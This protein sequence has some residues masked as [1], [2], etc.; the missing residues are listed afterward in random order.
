MRKGLRY[1][2]LSALL[3]AVF[4]NVLAWNSSTFC[5]FYVSNIF[6]V[7]LNTYGKWTSRFP[8]SVG[9]I[10]IVLAVALLIVFVVFT[11]IA[12]IFLMSKK[13]KQKQEKWT[14]KA[15]YK[16]LRFR[17]NYGR[18]NAFF[19]SLLVAITWI[20]TLNCYILYHCTTFEEKYWEDIVTKDEY[21]IEELGMLRDFVVTRANQYAKMM[22]RDENGLILYDGNMEEEA[23]RAMQNLGEVYP[24]LAGFYTTPKKIAA[25]EFLSQQYMKGYY[26][27]F[28]LEANYNDVMYIMSKPATMCHELAHTKGFI[29]EDEANL[30]GFLACLHSDDILFQYSGY[31]SVL[32][33]ID[34]D[35]YKSVDENKQIYN[36][37]VKISSQV[38]KDRVFLTEDAWTKVEKKAVISTKTLK[39][40]SDTFTNTTLVLNGVEQGSA[41]YREVVGLLLDYYI[42]MD[43]VRMK[44]EYMAQ[45]TD[46]GIK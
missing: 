14:S 35:F 20:M 24:Q 4:I 22:E 33:Y 23:I 15:E 10:M 40:A 9:E 8:F 38:K 27:P 28:S 17:R 29:Y 44:E 21:T 26:F 12:V 19:A 41:S 11:L 46:E 1:F 2:L 6:P 18:Y 36:S 25:S 16:W 3:L 32:N 34:N 43:D 13:T 45:L 5:D 42:C 7:W 37:H 31:L 30:I 39:K